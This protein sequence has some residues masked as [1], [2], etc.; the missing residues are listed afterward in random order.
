MAVN[1]IYRTSATA[2]GS[3]ATSRGRAVNHWMASRNA[4]THTTPS[5]TTAHQGAPTTT[6]V[7]PMTKATQAS[8]IIPANG[9]GERGSRTGDCGTPSR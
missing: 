3:T 9:Q 2:T 6:G 4:T 1:V 7:A 8:P 5:T